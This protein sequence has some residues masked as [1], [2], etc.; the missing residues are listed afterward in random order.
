LGPRK[1]SPSPAFLVDK[2]LKR[3]IRKRSQHPK[4]VNK[5]A[6]AG[7]VAP[8]QKVQLRRQAMNVV[9]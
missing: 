6:L 4:E 7:A 2:D 3:F 5:I 9:T 8:D 1:K